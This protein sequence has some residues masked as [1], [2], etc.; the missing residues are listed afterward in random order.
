MAYRGFAGNDGEFQEKDHGNW[1]TYRI[2]SDAWAKENNL[3]HEI[4]VLDGIRYARILETVAYVAT[5][6]D[7]MNR[8][9][10]EKWVLKKHNKF[11]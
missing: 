1:F 9:V 2:T 5:D 7:S 3:T 10:T 4:D 11:S 8:A 6:V